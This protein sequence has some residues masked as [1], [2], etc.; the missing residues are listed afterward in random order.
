M[1]SLIVPT[2]N[3]EKYIQNLLNK[4]NDQ[5]IKPDEILL[6]DSSSEDNTRRIAESLGTRVISIDRK[7]FDHGGTRNFAVKA[8]SG[9]IAI[10]FTQ[11][12]IPANE[13][14]IE[15]LIKPLQ[16]KKLA[17]CYGRQIANKD[18][19]PLER[20]ARTFNYPVKPLIKGEKD[21]KLLGIKT[22]FC[23]N[24][25][26]AIRKKEFYE[27]GGFPENVIMNEDMVFA[28]KLIMKGYKV[29]YEPSAIVYHSHN[30]SL[31]N[32]FKRYFDIGVSLNRYRLIPDIVRAEGEGY[33]YLM[34]EIKF[35]LK[36][37]NACW[38]PYVFV[39]TAAK[40]AGFRL[41]LA[42]E[43]LPTAFKKKISM[44]KYFWDQEKLKK[45]R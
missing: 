12:A 28:A 33:K 5:T 26:S 44:H 23:S 4:I 10:F 45:I 27:V 30:Y 41:G 15:N 24:V 22:F 18:S 7:N 9:E 6:I 25:C 43:K 36:E 19:T 29:A 40:Y 2:F 31:L 8:S 34:E 21:I 38:I 16:D 3:A 32:Q 42:E 11:D 13:Y 14:L 1:I 35:L 20:F 39:E 17:L 37:N